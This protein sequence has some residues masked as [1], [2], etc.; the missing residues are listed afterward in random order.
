MCVVRLLIKFSTVVV[1]ATQ[2]CVWPGLAT[3]D[4]KVDVGRPGLALQ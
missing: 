4:Q 1:T 2:F 3:V